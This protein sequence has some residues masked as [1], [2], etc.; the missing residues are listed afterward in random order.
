MQQTPN[1]NH[2]VNDPSLEWNHQRSILR[3]ISDAWKLF[4]IHIKAEVKY[5]L[6]VALTASMAYAF[7]IEQFRMYAMDH[8]VPAHHLM[9]MSASDLSAY[10]LMPDPVQAVLMLLGTVLAV[11]LAFF[12]NGRSFGLLSH[13]AHTS[14]FPTL[15]HHSPFLNVTDRRFAHRLFS[16]SIFWFLL[17][18]VAACILGALAW[19]VNRW[20]LA[21]ALPLLIWAMPA[22]VA[23]TTYHVF[24][25]YNY[26]E[27]LRQAICKRWGGFFT[28]LL[29]TSLPMLLARYVALLPLNA[30]IQASYAIAD[31]W[32]MGDQP[33]YP[34]ALPFL[35]FVLN[36]LG[37]TFY[38]LASLFPIYAFTLYANPVKEKF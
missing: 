23:S 1:M 13:Y 29:I 2:Q 37:F 11:V 10:A 24:Y 18:V 6:P 35:F 33:T 26:K 21:A 31:T 12:V 20:C 30:Y 5:L 16:I 19:K 17:L 4:A 32:L 28:I 38:A 15:T 8:L 9:Q 36:T 7:C 14:Q 22:T 25:A 3:S 34:S 27:S